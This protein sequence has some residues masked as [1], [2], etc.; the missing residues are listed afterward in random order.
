M[1]MFPELPFLSPMTP[2]SPTLLIQL[3]HPISLTLYLSS[4]YYL[5]PPNPPQILDHI[6]YPTPPLK[7]IPPS[8]SCFNTLLLLL[9][10]LLFIFLVLFFLHAEVAPIEVFKVPKVP[11]LLSLFIEWVTTLRGSMTGKGH[12][13]SEGIKSL[14]HR[15]LMCTTQEKLSSRGTWQCGMAQRSMEITMVEDKVATCVRCWWS[16]HRCEHLC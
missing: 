1:P 6:M 14:F 8:L 15:I 9:L 10:I 7:Y 13:N 12:S 4:S 3:Y 2:I 5:I 16:T 11:S